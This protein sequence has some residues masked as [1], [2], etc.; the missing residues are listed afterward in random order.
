MHAQKFQLH[1][2]TSVL[3]IL[4]QREL[5]H[6]FRPG[7]LWVPAQKINGFWVFGPTHTIAQRTKVILKSDSECSSNTLVIVY[8]FSQPKP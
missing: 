5:P 6:A 7:C 1:S 4:L 8:S 3:S 2:D